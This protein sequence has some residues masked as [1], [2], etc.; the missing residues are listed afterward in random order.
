MRP[1][2]YEAEGFNGVLEF[3]LP[4]GLIV[5]FTIGE[6]PKRT[7]IVRQTTKRDKLKANE[8]PFPKQY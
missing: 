1:A 5:G 6:Y 4:S 7:N 2:I 8:K 3:F